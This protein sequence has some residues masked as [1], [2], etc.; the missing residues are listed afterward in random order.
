MPSSEESKKLRFPVELNASSL[1]HVDGK[2]QDDT[3]RTM[4]G[5]GNATRT[6]TADGV[7][8]KKTRRKTK[9][10]TKLSMS[11]AHMID[12]K[13]VGLGT[14][15]IFMSQSS[16]AIEMH[17]K[18]VRRQEQSFF[19]TRFLTTLVAASL[20]FVVYLITLETMMSCALSLGLTIFW[21]KKGSAETYAGSGMDWVIL[22]F[23][24]VTPITVTIQQAFTR[25]ERALYEISRIRSCCFQIYNSHNIW[26][27]SGGEGRESVMTKEEWLKHTDEVLEHL[28]GIGDE[29]CRFLTLPTSSRSYHRMLKGGRRKAASIVE[30]GYRL[31]DS[32]YTQR[33]IKLS[34]LTEKLKSLGLSG[35]EASRIRQYERFIEKQS[36]SSEL[37]R[38]IEL[39]KLYA[40]LGECLPCSFLHF[41]LRHSLNLP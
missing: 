11:M 37:S 4:N 12:K 22:G 10:K 24:V 8:H 41:M 13:T 31:L 25:R 1:E 17:E 36:K 14:G 3:V 23:A 32:L 29:L 15:A 6:A 9:T 2:I 38:C 34:I 30:V 20:V 5:Y 21:Y 33:V 39:H 7:D 35:S 26:D 18:E 40:V 27:W 28:V 19:L 16:G